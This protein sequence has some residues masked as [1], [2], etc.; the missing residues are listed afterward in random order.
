MLGPKYSE[1]K[2]AELCLNDG[3]DKIDRRFKILECLGE[4]SYGI[5]YKA[6]D[7]ISY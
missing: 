3:D 2:V 6:F 1:R 7:H 4:G 5:V